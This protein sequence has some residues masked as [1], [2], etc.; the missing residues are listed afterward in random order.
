M[1]HAT[2]VLLE[3]HNAKI[4]SSYCHF[5]QHKNEQSPF[6]FDHLC[7]IVKNGL[8]EDIL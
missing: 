2:I 1:L 4:T 7:P 3:S 8:P 5:D 6:I